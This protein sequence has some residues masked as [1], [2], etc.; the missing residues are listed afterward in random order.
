MI[1]IK[2]R[3]MK[4]YKVKIYKENK[5]IENFNLLSKEGFKKISKYWIRSGWDNKHVYTFTW[6]GRPIIQLPEDL[7]RLQEFLFVEK[8]DLIIET[9]IAHGGGLIFYS[10]IMRSIKK[11]FEIIGIDIDIRSHNLKAIKKHAEYKKKFI[12]MFVGSSTEKKIIQ[13]VI[14]SLKKSKKSIIILDSNHSFQHVYDELNTY[15]KLLKKGSY[16]IACDAIEPFLGDDAPRLRNNYMKDNPLV[17][18]KK[19]LKNNKN[20]KLMEPKFLFN[21]SVINQRVTYWPQCYLKKIR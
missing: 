2:R 21:E 8:P 5:L 3:Y 17:A 14:P 4:K 11:K 18:I 7:I 16:I 13:K 15:S 12:K 19:F 6:L 10:N 1:F 9:G 20:F